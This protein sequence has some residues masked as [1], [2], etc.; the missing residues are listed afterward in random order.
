MTIVDLEEH[1]AVQI[2]LR[3]KAMLCN[4]SRLT[5]NCSCLYK[6]ACIYDSFRE[7]ITFHDWHLRA[8][9]MMTIEF[10]ASIRTVNQCCS[11][12]PV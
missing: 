12:Y 9:G 4:K 1:P 6:A 5:L 3:C 7:K 11:R 8:N 2:L 10:Q